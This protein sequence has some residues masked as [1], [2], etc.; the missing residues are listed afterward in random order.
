V[1]NDPHVIEAYLG[2]T[3][4]EDVPPEGGVLAALPDEAPADTDSRAGF[5]S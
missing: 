2:Q 1:R 5:G 3:L 4:D